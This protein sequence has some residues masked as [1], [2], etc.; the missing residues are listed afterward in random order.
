MAELFAPLDRLLVGGGDPRLTIDPAT[1][2]NEYGCQPF[3]CPDTLSFSSS[4]ATSIS[5]RAYDRARDARESLMQS[6]IAVGIEAAFDARIEALRDELKA[7]LGLSRTRADIVFSPSG[8]DSQLQALFLARALLGPALTTIVVAADQTGSGTVNTARGYHF[9]AATANGNRVRKGQPIAGLA[10]SVDSVALR[11]F[12]EAGQP[13]PQTA[14]DS[15]VLGAVER[16]IAGGSKVLLQIMDSSKFGWRAPSDQCLDEI[17]ARW[18]GRVQIVVDACQMRLGRARLRNY[19]DRGYMV[20]VTGSKFFTGP[21]FSG[22]LLVPSALAGDID[23]ATDIAPGLFEYSSRSDWP[24][25]WPNLRS[26]FPIRTNFGQWLR[27]EAALEEIGA[28][29]RVPDEFRRMAL[30]TFGN[31]VER[32]I[33]SSPSLRLLPPQQRPAGADDEELAQRTIYSFVIRHGTRVLSLDDCRKLYRALARGAANAA[34]ADDREIA[35]EPCLIGQPV[36]LGCDERHPAAALRISASARLVTQAWSPDEATARGNLQRALDQVG[37]AVAKLE[38][39]LAGTGGLESAGVAMELDRGAAGGLARYPSADRIGF[40]RLTTMA[41]EGTDLRPLRDQLISKLAAGTADAGEGLDLSLITQLLGDRQAGIA[42]QAEVLA[43]HQLY[44]SPCS[45]Q[46]PGLRVLALAAAIDMGGNTP[47]EF[48]LENSGIELQTLY[49]VAGV[50][51]PAPLPEHDVAIVIA[52]DSE[53]C[54]EA[55]RKIDVVASRWPRPLLNPPRLVRHLDRDKLH[56]LLCGIEG[57]DI[58]ATLGLTRAQLSDAAR[59]NV[60]FPDVTGELR[61]PVIIRPRGSHAGV[62]L[63]KVDD[64]AM[65]ER[66]LADRLEQEFFV[67]RFVDYANQD[68]LFRK[69]RIVFVDGRPFACHM[70]IA[71]RWDIWYLNAGMAFSAEKRLEEESFMRDFDGDFAVRHRSALAAIAGRVGLDY[72]TIDCA[73][74]KNGE[75]LIFEADNTAVVHNMD[76]PE[77]FPY[78]PPQMRKI[79]DAFAAMLHRRARRGQEH[80]A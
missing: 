51:L 3:P 36:A 75:L 58:P 57:L 52:S 9:S 21:P 13:C 68:G 66:Y 11:L 76:S 28:Y 40:A 23:A 16:S 26:R 73:E 29:F 80:A 63:A 72:F 69:Y 56:G 17:S 74:N 59:S 33:A 38:S 64:G 6:A 25:N 32:I 42:I 35:A 79:F 55:L 12:D 78:K 5:Q 14:S 20:L 24:A 65:V 7:C 77:L 43:F 60:G 37:T 49:V 46:K 41:F 48:L 44:R 22:A 53:E 8:T 1:G 39:L 34:G 54:L 45:S 2:L 50:D 47:I 62:G 31:G 10:H 71:D 70:A 4:T 61:Y 27:W 67:A 19:L 30:T 18:P 15:Q